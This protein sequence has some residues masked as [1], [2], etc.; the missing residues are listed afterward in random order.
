[1]KVTLSGAAHGT[2]DNAQTI[3]D[4]FVALEK[5]FAA[6]LT[7]RA[8]ENEMGSKRQNNKTITD[9]GAEIENLATKLAAAHVSQG[10]FATEAAAA[11]IVEWPMEIGR[12]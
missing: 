8:V 3:N 12:I 6:K 2:I 5:K 7:P 4:A 9:F 11:N 1:M 10:T